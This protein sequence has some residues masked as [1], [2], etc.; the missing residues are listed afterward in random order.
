M[1]DREDA[2]QLKQ[3]TDLELVGKKVRMRSVRPSDAPGAF[4]LLSDKRVTRTLLWDGPSSVD[5]L[6]DS[7]TRMG[8]PGTRVGDERAYNFAIELAGVRGIVGSI[9]ARPRLHPHQI[10]I[11]YWLGVPYWNKGLMTDAVRLT[12]HFCFEHLNAV[13]VYASVFMGNIGS[14]R[15]LEKCGFTLDGTLRHHA[16][17]REKWLDEW[18]LSLL[19]TEWEANRD[20][21]R[22]SETSPSD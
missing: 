6:S 13:R 15:V 20:W 17:K 21:Y 10:D 2:A 16:L 4:E 3:H 7:Y 5:E 22:P 14:R 18:F 1:G 9:S 12:T 19:R 11:G 8:L